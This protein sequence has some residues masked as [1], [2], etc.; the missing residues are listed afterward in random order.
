MAAIA[1]QNSPD[2]LSKDIMIGNN[3]AATV[4]PSGLIVPKQSLA[5]QSTIVLAG[6]SEIILAIPDGVSEVDISFGDLV[7][8]STSA[9][10]LTL[11]TSSAFLAAG[12]SASGSVVYNASGSIVGQVTSDACLPIWHTAA[13]QVYGGN[14]RLRLVDP[15]VNEWI[16]EGSGAMNS[17]GTYVNW[18]SSMTTRLPLSDKLARV[19]LFGAV[20][21]NF[22][23][24]KLNYTY[25]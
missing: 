21:G 23:A 7:Q 2:G 16:A 17:S 18:L 1:F 5:N 14:L 20:G 10:A 19:R 3:K 22:T 24:G 11:G 25:R 6:K 4:L 9:I 12:Y 15:A 13:P 8:N